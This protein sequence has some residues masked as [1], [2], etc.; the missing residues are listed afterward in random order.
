L[1]KIKKGNREIERE[2][3]KEIV[4]GRVAGGWKEGGG[5]KIPTRSSLVQA[6]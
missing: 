3:G 4:A 1:K 2:E 5:G 6:T